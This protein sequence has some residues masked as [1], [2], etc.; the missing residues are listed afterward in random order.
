M[1]F[2]MMLAAA[3]LTTSAFAADVDFS[4]VLTD[5][6]GATVIDCVGSDCA[7]KPPL[8]L[9]KVAM[10]ALTA[11]YQDEQSL[12]GEEKF[13]RGQLAE[14]VYAGGAVAISAEDTALIKRLIAKGYGPLIVLKAWRLLDPAT[15]K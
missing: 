6:D 5:Q 1:R 15:A 12:A 10:R 11:S 8:T 2:V 14:K 7:G 3:L 4:A 9:G 13:K